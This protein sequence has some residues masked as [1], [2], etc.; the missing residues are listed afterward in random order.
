MEIAYALE[1]M[2]QKDPT[3]Y[4]HIVGTYKK[5]TELAIKYKADLY[6][7]QI[8]AILHDYAKNDAHD[9]LKSLIEKHLDLYHLNYS[10][11]IYHGL[12]G[13]YLVEHEL[14]IKD[15]SILNAIKYHVTGHQEMDHLAKIVF[16]A[17]YI[18][19]NRIHQGVEFCRYL[20]EVDLDLALLGCLSGTIA[21]LKEIDA[22]IHPWTLQTYKHYLKKVGNKNYESIRNNYFS[23]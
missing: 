10:P 20:S 16:I 13:A 1:L 2:K 8:A 9:V 12:V 11:I 22:S 19:E 3:R 6:K 4:Q 15:P 18:E 14:G 21:Y 23:L 5:A 17:D 7:T